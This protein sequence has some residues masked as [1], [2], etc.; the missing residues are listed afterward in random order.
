MYMFVPK[1][2]PSISSKE[3]RT[4]WITCCH[5]L[6]GRVEIGMQYVARRCNVYQWNDNWEHGKGDHIFVTVIFMAMICV[7]KEFSNQ[8]TNKQ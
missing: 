2:A 3:L 4:V 1:L 8:S 5:L 7:W 6:R